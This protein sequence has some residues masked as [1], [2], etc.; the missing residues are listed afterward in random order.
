MTDDDRFADWLG[1]TDG[2]LQLSAEPL[3]VR[4]E[5]VAAALSARASLRASLEADPPQPPSRALAET[6]RK[7]ERD[8]EE[9]LSGLRARL[10]HEIDTVRQRRTATRGYRPARARRPAFVS[11]S[12]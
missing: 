10:S 11:R 2:L 9:H 5:A 8:L 6:L 3:G 1:V 12:I 4:L 7:A